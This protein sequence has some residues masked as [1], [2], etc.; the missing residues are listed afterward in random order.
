MLSVFDRLSEPAIWPGLEEFPS[1]L[2]EGHEPRFGREASHRPKRWD[3]GT[4]LAIYEHEK[5]TWLFRVYIYVHIYV[6][7]YISYRGLYYPIMF[8]DVGAFCIPVSLPAS[9]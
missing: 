7:I 6:Y 5:K 8:Q 9:S 4:L 1:R 2:A 3:P